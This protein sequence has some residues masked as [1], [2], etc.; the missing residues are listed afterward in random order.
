MSKTL[1][2]NSINY[3]VN[4]KAGCIRLFIIEMIGSGLRNVL[5]FLPNKLCNGISSVTISTAPLL[6]IRSFSVLTFIKKVTNLN[7]H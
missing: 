2:I 3:N 5:L 7:N 4:Y 6:I 1:R